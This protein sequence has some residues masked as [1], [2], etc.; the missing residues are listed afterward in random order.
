MSYHRFTFRV[1]SRLY[2]NLTYPVETTIAWLPLRCTEICCWFS[3]LQESL[4]SFILLGRVA[5]RLDRPCIIMRKHV[6]TK[7]FESRI[8]ISTASFCAHTFSEG[9]S[10]TRLFGNEQA[11]F[12]TLLHLTQAPFFSMLA[13]SQPGLNPCKRTWLLRVHDRPRS[14]PPDPNISRFGFIDSDW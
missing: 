8:D 4:Q 12:I 10:G 3:S 14:N 1:S 11:I 6:E 2:L 9:S 7:N 13:P 5:S